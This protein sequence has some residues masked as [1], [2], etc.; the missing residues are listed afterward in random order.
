MAQRWSFEEEYIV[1]DFA[2]GYMLRA[3]S[4]QEL[5]HLSLRLKEI[6]GHVR[7]ESILRKKIRI[8]Q[9]AFAGNDSPYATKQMRGISDAY[10][11][12]LINP[13]Y[14]E[15]LASR[16]NQLDSISESDE[17]YIGDDIQFLTSS[18]H[19]LRP[20]VARKPSFKE[21]LIDFIEK[22]GMTDAQVYKASRVS[23]DK[24]NHI[25]NGRKGK[26]KKATTNN[27]SV[28]VSRRTIMQLCL[29]LRLSYEEALILMQS[30]GCYFQLSEDIDRVVVTFL[31]AGDYDMDEINIELYERGLQVFSE[32]RYDAM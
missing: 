21:V 22:S 26:N 4:K 27:N 10:I 17:L 24:F 8:Y 6:S 12:R 16:I 13:E 31:Q 19:H 2:Y 3:I 7:R 20:L 23:R 5:L 25:F 18:L 30:A 11:K 15:K 32:S 9:D 1:C 14:Y 29:G 28:G